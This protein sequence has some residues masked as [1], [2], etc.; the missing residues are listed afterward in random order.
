MKYKDYYEILGV[1]K[2]ATNAEIKSAYRKLARKYHPD[3]NK[4]PDAQAKF[5][6][7]NEAYEVLGDKEKRQRYDTLGS[8]W[9][10][11]AD[12]T[13][14]PGFEGFNF[15]NFSSTGANTGGFSDF[16]SA[17]F[18]DIMNQQGGFSRTSSRSSNFGGGFGGDFSNFSNFS[19]GARGGFS[20]F[21]QRQ[22]QA[23][24]PQAKEE[25]LDIIQNVFLNVEDLIKCPKKTVTIS[26]YQQ[27]SQCHGSKQGFCSNCMG[28]GLEKV[29]KNI[30]FKVPKF[31][32]EGQKI[33][34]KGEGKRG[35]DGSMGDVYLI[36]K[37]K[38]DD[39]E[40]DGFDVL[41]EV[42]LLPYEAVL[43]AEKTIKTPKDGNIKIKIPKNTS[44]GKKLRLKNLGLEKKDGSKGDFVAKIK[45][46][47]KEDLSLEAIKLYEELKKL[48]S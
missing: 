48:N 2:D 36:V 45:I 30:T 32:K 43:G 35:L 26:S 25:S 15:S 41:K 16:F 10:Q 44:S 38:D 31:V 29:T 39:F 3:V 4:A 13:P 21:S 1:K 7:I 28:T 46:V 17:I 14:P 12:F 20:N 40:I 11:G 24:K 9:S 33:R 34:L 23:S 27:C 18:G 42:D 37:I 5:K 47:L 6:D 19:S 8:S 22:S